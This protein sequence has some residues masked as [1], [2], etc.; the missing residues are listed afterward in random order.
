[1]LYVSSHSVKKHLFIENYKILKICFPDTLDSDDIN[2]SPTGVLPG[3]KG[4]NKLPFFQDVYGYITF[5][6]P[7]CMNKL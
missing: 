1:M 5:R 2:R 4:L 6:E 7:E 3:I